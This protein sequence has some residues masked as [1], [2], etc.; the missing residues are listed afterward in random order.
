MI[1]ETST[2][3]IW[4]NDKLEP[5]VFIGKAAEPRLYDLRLPGGKIVKR[6]MVSILTAD[7]LPDNNR[8]TQGTMLTHLEQN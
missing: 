3:Y 2:V 7:Q 5:V 1:K 8:T 4:R 6:L